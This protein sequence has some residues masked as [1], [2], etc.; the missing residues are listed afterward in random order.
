MD[1]ACVLL[2]FSYFFFKI[3]FLLSFLRLNY[4][5]RLASETVSS[6]KKVCSNSHTFFSIAKMLKTLFIVGFQKYIGVDKV[7]LDEE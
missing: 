6:K 1:P 2:R 4:F 7:R 3:L 5:L